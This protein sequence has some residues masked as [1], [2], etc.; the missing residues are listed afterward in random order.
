MKA[1]ELADMSDKIFDDVDMQ[2]VPAELRQ[3][4]LVEA[5]LQPPPAFRSADPSFGAIISTSP[6]SRATAII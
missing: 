6:L 5:G 3:A 4:T 1:H 2:I